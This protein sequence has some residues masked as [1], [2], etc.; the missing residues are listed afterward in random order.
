MDEMENEG[1]AEPI[2]L[3]PLDPWSGGD[4]LELL[5][6]RIRAATFRERR[7]K[8]ASLGLTGLLIRWQRPILALAVIVIALS[9]VVLM[10]IPRPRATTADSASARLG[11]ERGW[12]AWVVDGAQPT[13]P[14][15]LE[16]G[17]APE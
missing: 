4:R 10:A 15:L 9:A 5:V 7:R 13:A 6:R 1:G 12:T 8:Q 16:P 17:E 3:S 2:D 11:L 14:E